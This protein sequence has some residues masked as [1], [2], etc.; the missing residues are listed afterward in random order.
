MLSPVTIE[1]VLNPA[2]ACLRAVPVVLRRQ[3]LA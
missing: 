2:H 3:G 1:E